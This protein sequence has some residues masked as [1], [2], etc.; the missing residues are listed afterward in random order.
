MERYLRAV[1][2]R[3][4]RC[5][6]WWSALSRLVN[7]LQLSLHVLVPITS[8]V[9]DQGLEHFREGEK[10]PVFS[11]P[12]DQHVGLNEAVKDLLNK[13]VDHHVNTFKLVCQDSWQCFDPLVQLGLYRKQFITHVDDATPGDSRWRTVLQVSCLQQ[14]RYLICQRNDFSCDQVEALIVVQD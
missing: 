14:H 1:S 4:H 10:N 3:R 7:F 11:D 2:G 13:E 9:V 8:V 6:S 5:E 12:V